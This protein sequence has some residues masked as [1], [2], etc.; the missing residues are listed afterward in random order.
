[1][2]GKTNKE[3]NGSVASGQMHNVVDIAV[4]RTAP[5]QFVKLKLG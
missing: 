3:K 4:E 2:S 5:K 1:M